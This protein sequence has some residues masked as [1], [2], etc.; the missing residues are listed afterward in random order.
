MGKRKVEW[1]DN[2]SIELHAVMMYLRN[3]HSARTAAKFYADVEERI[4]FVKDNPER[5]AV[6]PKDE[7]V[8]VV[9]VRKNWK[10]YYRI[11]SKDDFVVLN[12]WNSKRNPNTAPY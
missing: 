3:E 7:N 9:I 10:L 8:R 4:N 2:G 6:A 12:F 1:T 5:G 11:N